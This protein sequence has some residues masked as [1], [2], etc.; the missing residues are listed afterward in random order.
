M[1]DNREGNKGFMRE[2]AP[3]IAE[4]GP[5]CHRTLRGRMIFFLA[6][7]S[8]FAA[9]LLPLFEGWAGGRA[10]I[11]EELL[12]VLMRKQSA[13]AVSATTFAPSRLVLE[14]SLLLRQFGPEI[15]MEMAR[16]SHWTLSSEDQRL[17]E[18][19]QK[20]VL[21]EDNIYALR[22]WTQSDPGLYQQL[23][24][25]LRSFLDLDSPPSK[26]LS[27]EIGDEELPVDLP[28][29]AGGPIRRLLATLHHPKSSPQERSQSARELGSFKYQEV[30]IS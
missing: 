16:G 11:V 20:I 2:R 13:A 25:D 30:R 24:P 27:M 19:L 18:E 10:R 3:K 6:T 9:L 1:R 21:R 28:E 8:F 14:R 17:I 22:I 12:S 15:L 7:L 29:S 26:L 5:F 4:E 23:L